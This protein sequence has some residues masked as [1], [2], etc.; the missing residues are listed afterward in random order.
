MRGVISL[1]YSVLADPSEKATYML[2]WERDLQIEW[3]LDT[4]HTNVIRSYRGILNNYLVEGDLKFSSRWY[5][6][7][8]RLTKFYFQSAPHCFRG[9]G[10]IG[11]LFHTLWECPKI[12]GY[13]NRIFNL[14]RKST[15]LPDQTEDLLDNAGKDF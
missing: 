11:S 10:H 3:D 2:N 4:W 12:R 6:V 1:I 14:I 13:W 7:L 5:L 15:A 9:C 8:T